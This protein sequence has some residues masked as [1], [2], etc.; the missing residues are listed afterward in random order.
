MKHIAI[1]PNYSG[2][3]GMINGGEISPNFLVKAE[4][5]GKVY[6]SNSNGYKLVMS[7]GDTYNMYKVGPSGFEHL[8]ASFAGT[9]YI[10]FQILDAN[11]TPVTTSFDWY[12]DANNHAD[13]NCPGGNF[14]YEGSE[15]GITDFEV[16]WVQI[17]GFGSGDTYVGYQVYFEP[18]VDPHV[19]VIGYYYMTDEEV[20]S[21]AG[22]EWDPDNQVCVLPSCEEQGLCGDDPNTCYECTC[23]DQYEEGTQELCECQGMYWWG[24]ECHDEPESEPTCEEQYEEG[25]QERCE[26]DGKYWWGDECHDEEEPESESDEEE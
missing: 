16:D 10:A 1:I 26:C 15:T 13:P 5:D 22:G 9:N 11:G 6:F 14:T 25:T 17:E 24:D 23:E 3:T 21:C 19:N 8:E 12:C 4:N 2:I 18:G 20:C 7:G